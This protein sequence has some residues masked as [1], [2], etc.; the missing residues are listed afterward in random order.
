MQFKRNLNQ[1]WENGATR[2]VVLLIIVLLLFVTLIILS[3]SRWE[4]NSPIVRLSRNFKA[5]GRSP[6][7]SVTVQD[8]E[9]GIKNISVILRQKDQV[10]PLMDEHYS[11]PSTLN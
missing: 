7:L 11:G 1:E 9:T 3:W 2:L 6:S 5:L 4:S 8:S 10:I